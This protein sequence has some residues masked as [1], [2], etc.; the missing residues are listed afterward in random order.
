MI[1][2]PRV[3]STKEDFYNL[4]PDFP[5]QVK[6]VLQ[7]L[8]DD[9]FIWI[10]DKEVAA[11]QPHVDSNKIKVVPTTR[12][13]KD[14]FM[15]MKLVEDTN[16]EFFRLGWTVAEANTFLDKTKKKEGK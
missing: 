8:M 7:N 5:K 16:A 3:L 1:G 10:E 13:G 14:I 6:E 15:Q 12:D 4:K 11:N 2:F 9:R